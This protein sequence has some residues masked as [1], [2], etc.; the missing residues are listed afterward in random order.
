MQIKCKEFVDGPPAAAAKGT[1][2]MLVR[3]LTIAALSAA[4]LAACES[5]PSIGGDGGGGPNFAAGS[6]LSGRL[7]EADRE[8]LA[9]AVAA[10][11]ETGEPRRWRGRRATGVVEPAGYS[12]GN[13][14]TDPTARLPLARPDI[15]TDE[16]MEIEL[17]LYAL[18]SNSNVRIGPGT[19]Y[20]VADTLPSGVGVEVVG[21][22]VDKPWMMVAVDGTVRGYIHEN[23]MIRAPG[24]ELELAGGP[25]RRPVLCRA[26]AQRIHI[27][28]ERDE[29]TGAACRDG[30]G[31]RL[32]A[33]PAPEAPEDERLEF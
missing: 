7:V 10:A 12:L 22:V 11:V 24:A 20:E 27:F 5:L 8:A 17:G 32:A 33:E 4:C 13:L 23:L 29:W 18:T 2:P 14:K 25:R 19:D 15:V 30:A 1:P 9:A 31:W 3:T 16:S 6:V 21:D 28:S 26:F